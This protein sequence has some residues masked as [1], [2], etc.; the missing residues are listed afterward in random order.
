MTIPPN[1]ERIKKWLAN[2][3]PE[4]DIAKNLGVAS[5]TWRKWKNENSAFS[6]IFGDVEV[7]PRVE[8]LENTMFKL[9]QGYTM[10]VTKGM[11][12]KASD[13]SEHVEEYKETL[14]VPPNYNAIRFLLVNWSD[15]YSNDPAAIRQRQVEFEHKK[16]MDEEN[17]W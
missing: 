4:K 17:N 12:V 16:K 14:H 11:K 6:A 15:K 10:S 13:G 8:K 1:L 2:G 7:I 3:V 5:S 9:A